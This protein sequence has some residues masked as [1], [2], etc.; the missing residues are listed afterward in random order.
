M[1]ERPSNQVDGKGGI[2]F[3]DKKEPLR[4][5]NIRCYRIAE[6]TEEIDESAFEGCDKL[7]VLYLPYT[8]SDEVDC[9]TSCLRTQETLC[10]GTG[11]TWKRVM[12]RMIMCVKGAWHCINLFGKM[13]VYFLSEHIRGS[14]KN[15][16]SSYI[17]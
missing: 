5:P 17:F 14:P 9:L 6:G 4:C 11:H 8:M 1:K 15:E 2:Y 12:T 16:A 13:L 3:T 10:T 7:E